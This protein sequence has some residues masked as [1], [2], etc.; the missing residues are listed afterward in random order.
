[1]DQFELPATIRLQ[2]RTGHGQKERDL[3]PLE[4]A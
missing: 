1:M 4:P 2:N 3:G